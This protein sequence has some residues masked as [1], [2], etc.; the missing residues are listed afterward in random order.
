VWRGGH[1]REWHIP[2]RADG[3]AGKLS[4]TISGSP[5]W[6][7]WRRFHH[8]RSLELNTTGVDVAVTT[9][10]V[11]FDYHGPDRRN[12]IRVG[13]TVNL[14][15]TVANTL[16]TSVGGAFSFERTTL[17]VNGAL[18]TVLQIG[19]TGGHADLSLGAAP[20]GFGH[21]HYRRLDRQA[22][23]VAG[24]LTVARWPSPG[25]PAWSRARC[26]APRWS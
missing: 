4:V 2:V 1:R 16:T 17:S 21:W 6:P 20:D 13:A 8:Q 19:L 22:G 3:L 14:S 12:F 11:P 24:K 18:A 26:A 7:T 25:C 23:G 9:G 10:P 5:A 15:I